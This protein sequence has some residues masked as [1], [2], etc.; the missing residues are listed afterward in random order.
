MGKREPPVPY[1]DG[2]A[3]VAQGIERSP[4][5]RK[6]AGS[7]PAGGTGS[8]SFGLVKREGCAVRSRMSV[9]ILLAVTLVA[10]GCNRQS[11]T[12]TPDEGAGS[13]GSGKGSANQSCL[14]TEQEVAA[15]LGVPSVTLEKETHPGGVTCGFKPVDEEER[16]AG[17]V[18]TDL[19]L[20]TSSS[21]RKEWERRMEVFKRSGAQYV[22]A[23]G[24]GEAAYFLKGGGSA[25]NRNEGLSAYK[26]SVAIDFTGNFDNPKVV[27]LAKTAIDRI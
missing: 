20:S 2:P 6:A 8:W 23:E 13:P 1:N 9:P 3:L 24:I 7:N 25:S 16:M 19:R 22:P 17:A 5:E 18:L 15:A 11:A 26:G 14:V 27:D 10:V 12:R 21:S 4:P